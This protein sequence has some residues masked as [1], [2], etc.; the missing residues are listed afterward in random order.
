MISP[1]SPP[2]GRPPAGRQPHVGG[3]RGF[4]L[5]EVIIV[6][7]ILGLVAGLVIARG[8][9]RSQ[10]LD[11]RAAAADVARILRGARG[12][13]IGTDRSVLV[14]V[15]VTRRAIAVDGGP[16]RTIPGNLAVAVQAVP[17]E[18]RGKT[19]AGIRF[20]PDGSASGGRIVLSDGSRRTQIAVDWLTGRVTIGDAPTS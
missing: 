6:V 11:M 3:Q 8:P 18:T 12:Q 19:L 17:Q 4:T 9:A 2:A 20:Q 13:A 16:I 1:I 5:L 10:T 7:V 14:L 15:D